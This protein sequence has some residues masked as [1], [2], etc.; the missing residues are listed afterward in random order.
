MGTGIA[1]RILGAGFDLTVFNRTRAKME[2]FLAKGAKGATDLK[3]AVA[4]ADVVVTSLMDDKSVLENASQ[5]VTAMK[6][7]AIHICVTTISPNCADELAGLHAANGSAYIAGPVVGRPN[8]AAA[9]EL[10]SLLAGAQDAATKVTPVCNAYSKKVAYVS[11]R[12]GAANTLKLCINYTTISIIETFSEAYSF[13]DKAG[14]NIDVLRDF[15]EEAMGHPALKMYAKKLRDRDFAGKGGFS[16]SG[17]LKD[18][19]LMLNTSSAIG[20]DLDIGKIVKR[21]METAVA[22]GMHEKDWSSIYEITRQQSGLS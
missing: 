21:K 1:G 14:T 7:G 10:L 6:P 8:A 9:G 19:T 17:G 20:V 5:F 16:M 12:H 2:P 15:L 4:G 13:A 3:S 22:N 18:V 11:E